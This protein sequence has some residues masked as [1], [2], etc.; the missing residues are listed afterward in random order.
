MNSLK[1]WLLGALVSHS[2]G[3]ILREVA[4]AETADTLPEAFGLA[5]AFGHDFQDAD[6]PR[7]KEWVTW[8]EAAGRTLLLIPPYRIHATALPTAWRVYRPDGLSIANGPALVR[9]LAS[10]MR[11][12]FDTRMQVPSELGGLSVTGGINTGLYRKHPHAG[13]FAITALPLWSLTVLDHKNDLIEWL[14]SL[15]ALAGEPI[16]VDLSSQ[17]F[18]E[19][20]PNRDHFALL[21]HLQSNTFSSREEALHQLADSPVLALPSELAEAGMMELEQAGLSSD[22]ELTAAGRDVLMNSPYGVYAEAME[23]NRQ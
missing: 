10:E 17:E 11:H 6:E 9:K 20:I 12:E 23:A 7:Q 16:A 5:I 2:R 4:D 15:H 13:L 14:T 8:C 22:G 19:F 1:I 3:R 18:D 21:L